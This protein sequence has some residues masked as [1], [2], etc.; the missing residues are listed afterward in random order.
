M[1]TSSTTSSFPI[2]APATWDAGTPPPPANDASGHE[3]GPGAPAAAG[4]GPLDGLLAL[5]SVH[6][7]L[8]RLAGGVVFRAA[9]IA[10]KAT[11]PAA[12]AT[13]GG[14]HAQVLEPGKSTGPAVTQ[15]QRHLNVWREH[16]WRA[17]G[18][19]GWPT[20]VLSDHGKF[21]G[22]T[23]DAVKEFQRA[24]K[25]PATGVAD[26]ATQNL[27]KVEGDLFY[28]GELDESE[29]VAMR[30]L[31]LES[32]QDGT[33]AE[34]LANLLT[35]PAFSKWTSPDFRR[36]ILDCVA[37][38][39]LDPTYVDALR[40]LLHYDW[41]K[42]DRYSLET[43]A[44]VKQ[45][46]GTASIADV[47]QQLRYEP[48][49]FRP[50]A[51]AAMREEAKLAT[52]AVAMGKNTTSG[53]LFGATGP[54]PDAAW[55]NP[56]E[57]VGRWTQNAHGVRGTHSGERCGPTSLLAGA[58][59]QGADVAAGVLDKT[60]AG[61]GQRLVDGE[62]RELQKIAERLRGHT[63]TFDD[64]SRAGDLL[65]RAAKTRTTMQY[66]LQNTP[67]LAELGSAKV[68]RMNE[69]AA[70]G[71]ALTEPQRRELSGLLSRA[72][73][74][75]VDVRIVDGPH[76]GK[77]VMVD[78]RPG[79]GATHEG[80]DVQELRHAAGAGGL[81]AQGIGY[82]T[83]SHFSAGKTLGYLKPGE[84]AV[85]QLAGDP[86]SNQADHYVTIGILADGRP[87]VYNPDPAQGD[88]TL[89]VGSARGPQPDAFHAELARYNE[90]AHQA[91][92]DRPLATK[93][94]YG[95]E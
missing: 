9:P 41:F 82:D 48:D 25:L 66:A 29:K 28:S 81:V 75:D 51:A 46:P 34:A 50:K 95:R 4:S 59:L 71:T 14:A 94:A 83:S 36:V 72:M 61:A 53:S 60:A 43:L 22:A 86:A 38:A 49:A 54:I 93:I 7:G 20:Q 17:E 8:Q 18:H 78:Y 65:Y 56:V 35:D 21:D 57:I 68:A 11:T 6:A 77:T 88:N 76:G 79:F 85:L 19:D 5:V 55:K 90:R 73:E 84:S 24:M 92:A 13:L 33:K 2:H 74:R 12:P 40:G 3:A 39:K 23:R 62:K 70:L 69:L 27:L 80:L 30:K 42:D 44:Y 32:S 91:S 15:L 10:A 37:N 67:A 31:V 52:A 45:H 89:T 47:R 63:A 87:Y 58:L 16:R 26:A 64:L 1:L